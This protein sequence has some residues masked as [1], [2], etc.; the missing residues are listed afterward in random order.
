MNNTG[1]ARPGTGEAERGRDLQEPRGGDRLSEP[2][3]TQ[4]CPA[5]VS[6]GHGGRGQL[7]LERPAEEQMEGEIP[8]FSLLF[9]DLLLVLP[10]V[11]SI[12]KPAK[13]GAGEIE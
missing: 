7:L 6:W 3:M 4:A 2:G 12:W 1:K 8:L 13:A 11:K 9:S 5:G 10:I